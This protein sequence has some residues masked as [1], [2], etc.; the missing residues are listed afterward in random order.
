MAVTGH[1]LHVDRAGTRVADD[2]GG[3]DCVDGRVH[4]HR[5]L[6][7]GRARRMADGPDGAQ[8]RRHRVRAPHV[9]RMDVHSVWPTSE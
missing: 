1:G 9:R 7:H 6:R 2:D 8:V 5:Q 3:A 4:R